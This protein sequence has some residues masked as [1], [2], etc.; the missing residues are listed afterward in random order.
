MGA[1]LMGGPPTVSHEAAAAG[2]QKSVCEALGLQVGHTASC[3]LAILRRHAAHVLQ[4]PWQQAPPVSPLWQSVAVS[5]VH[6]SPPVVARAALKVLQPPVAVQSDTGHA[7]A[8]TTR[9]RL[10]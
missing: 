8:A 4:H 10:T 1:I 5:T 2:L 7:A 3:R 9:Q 6:S